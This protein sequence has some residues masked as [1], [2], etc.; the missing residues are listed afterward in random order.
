MTTT[1]L[2]FA[3][4]NLTLGT[5][6]GFTGE[7]VAS[8]P[9]L[10]VVATNHEVLPVA[11]R[12]QFAVAMHSPR[13]GTLFRRVQLGSVEGY[14]RRYREDPEAAKARALETGTPLHYVI[15]LPATVS[16]GPKT[17]DVM[18]QLKDGQVIDFEGTR[19]LVSVDQNGSVKLKGI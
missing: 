3:F 12:D 5:D 11:D 18:I 13:Y 9:A 19:M 17:T 8:F 7:L 6:P 14:A 1:E 10:A 16:D 2:P 4:R 15:G